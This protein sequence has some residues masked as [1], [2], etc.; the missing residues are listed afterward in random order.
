MR[1]DNCRNGTE[2][3]LQRI[4]ACIW[5]RFVVLGLSLSLI[6]ANSAAVDPGLVEA[7]RAADWEAV[8]VLVEQGEDVDQARGGMTA[9]YWASHWGHTET[10]DLLIGAGADANAADDLGVAPLWTTAER[11]NVAIAQ[12][13]LDAGADPNVP[14]LSGETSVMTA[15]RAGKVELV[16]LL[17]AKGAD[18]NASA[19]RGQTALMWAAAQ[20][21]PGVV[22]VLLANGADV[23]ARSDTWS[24]RFQGGS[25][26]D[27]HPD[28]LVWIEQGGF[29]P[30]LFAARAGDLAVAERLVA[31][32]ADVND[33]TAWGISATIM[34]IHSVLERDWYFPQ[35]SRVG[36]RASIGGLLASPHA[37]PPN[38]AEELLEFLLEQG[39]DPNADEGGYTALHAAILRRTERSVRALLAHGADPNAVL[40]TSTPTRRDSFDFYFDQPFIGA[41]PFWLAAR[42][43][44]PNIM[45]LLADHGADPL[46]SLHVEYWGGGNRE[47]GWPRVTE[48]VTTA[49][50]A[51]LGM[52]RGRGYPFEQPRNRERMEALALETVQVALELGVDPNVVNAEGRTALDAARDGAFDRVVALLI[53]NGAVSEAE[54]RGRF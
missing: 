40:Q 37:R 26:S 47:L 19:T 43:N 45:R 29:T 5:Q 24:Q 48:G 10:V 28:L 38:D 21:H 41:T 42:F 18:P 35:Q 22:E 1:D 14:L 33:Q 44:Q 20:R 49:I 7:A 25:G 9:L 51:A 11:G 54:E 13:L 2:A 17:L 15:A 27:Q 50:M 53:E 31:G 34:A 30:L 8:R 46:F 16:T 12:K 32:G 4:G 3:V 6:G 39:A 36:N 52:P 23:H